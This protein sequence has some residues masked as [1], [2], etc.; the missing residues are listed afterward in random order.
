MYDGGDGAEP[1]DGYLELGTT[2][3][4]ENAEGF[5]FP[6]AAGAPEAAAVGTTF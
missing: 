2:P 4:D 5:G 1:A 3:A 6:D